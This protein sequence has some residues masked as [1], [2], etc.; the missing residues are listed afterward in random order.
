MSDD[1]C[2]SDD[3]KIKLYKYTIVSI[4]R[5]DEHILPDGQGQVLIVDPMDDCDF[6]NYVIAEYVKDHP[7]VRGVR[8]LR[9]CS[10][11]QCTWDKQ[12]LHYEEKQLDYL[13]SIAHSV[14]KIGGP[15]DDDDRP[16]RHPDDD[17]PRRGPAY[18]EEAPAGA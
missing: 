17:K 3:C 11:L 7:R 4:K 9:V 16:R 2:G 5:G 14:R 1:R 15:E 8:W 6:D 13:R 18:G 12:P 10:D